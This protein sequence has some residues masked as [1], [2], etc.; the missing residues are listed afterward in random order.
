MCVCACVWGLML[1]DAVFS[2]GMIR[3]HHHIHQ[4]KR[5]LEDNMV[6][7]SSKERS[8]RRNVIKMFLGVNCFYNQGV[9]KLQLFWGGGVFMVF[10]PVYLEN[11]YHLHV[12]V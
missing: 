9:F 3:G 1:K 5:V 7:L 12:Y 2:S 8:E 11:H 4:F 10:P 6:N